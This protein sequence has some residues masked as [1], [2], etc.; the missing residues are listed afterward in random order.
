MRDVATA[1]QFVQMALSQQGDRYIFGTEA[2]P[3][4][5][6]PSAF[7]CSELVEWALA[8]IGVRFV[9]GSVNQYGTCRNAGTLLSIDAAI[10]T[11]GSLLF[12][13]Q[14]S[15]QHVAISLGDGRTIEARGRAYGVGVFSAYG[16]NW[17]HAG[18]VPGL[19]YGGTPGVI[20]PVPAPLPPTEAPELNGTES[21]NLQQT[22][23]A[24]AGLQRQVQWL[25][26]L[27]GEMYQKVT[28]KDAPPQPR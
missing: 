25:E 19:A 27:L 14:T 11:R 4:N 24:V 8:R 1:E 10:R 9:D 22:H 2:A 6:N 26:N 15:P 18:R 23:D 28:G 12:R 21:T 3:S 7:D 17:N 5:P 16:R 20:R 13:T